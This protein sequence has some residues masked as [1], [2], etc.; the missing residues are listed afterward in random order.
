MPLG[1]GI[2]IR[3]FGTSQKRVHRLP[4]PAFHNV[5][6]GVDL[7]QPP[8][9]KPPPHSL[10]EN[11]TTTIPAPSAPCKLESPRFRIPIPAPCA[12]CK[13][14]LGTL[15]IRNSHIP[16]SNPGPQRSLQTRNSQIP[17]SNPGPQR[18]MQT[19]NSQIPNSNPGPQ[20]SLQ[21]RSLPLQI[22][23]FLIPTP[24]P[25]RPPSANGQEV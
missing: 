8:D 23:K 11:P 25:K 2:A 3:N 10:D 12:P 16:N 19:R 22:P 18:S 7:W 9:W 20:R 21:T 15:Q 6:G 5:A 24:G 14:Y 4:Q 13:R 17:N 1:A